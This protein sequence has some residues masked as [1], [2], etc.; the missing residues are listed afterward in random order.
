MKTIN[1]KIFIGLLILILITVSECANEYVPEPEN[2][3]DEEA[4]ND[5]DDDNDPDH[6]HENDHDSSE[7][8]AEDDFDSY[9]KKMLKDLNIEPNSTITRDRFKE[10]FKSVMFKG[11]DEIEEEEKELFNKVIEKVATNTPD[12]FPATDIHK[13]LDI[14]SMMSLIQDILADDIKEN[15]DSQIEDKEDL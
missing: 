15:K 5:E 11:G 9:T 10:L 13:Y 1:L 6:E 7:T 14:N 2:E 12:E 3:H 4:D 8:E